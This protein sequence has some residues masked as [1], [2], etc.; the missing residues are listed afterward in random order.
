MGIAPNDINA[1]LF[2]RWAI[3]TLVGWVLGLIV[4]I[5][6]SYALMALVDGEE[7]N[8][9][10]GLCMGAVLGLV[11]MFGARTVLPLGW[12]WVWGGA[13]GLGLAFIA[14]TVLATMMPAL[15]AA[16]DAW[17]VLVVIIGAAISGFLQ[18]PALRHHTSKAG[19]W[20]LASVVSWGV[21]WGI[22]AVVPELGLFLGGILLGFVSAGWLIWILK[23]S[24]AEA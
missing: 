8:L 14:V 2:W 22:T 21:A 15:A 23:P 3:L 7:T 24:R 1:G 9:I 20:T 13:V 10:V 6:F 4:A 12:R 5:G 16:S 18:V 17:L 19:M 11:Q